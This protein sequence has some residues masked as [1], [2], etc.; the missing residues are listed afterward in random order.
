MTDVESYLTYKIGDV[1]HKYYLPI[2]VTIGLCGN[3]LSL[4]VLLQKKHRN[5][6]CYILMAALAVNDSIVLCVAG[7]DWTG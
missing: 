6:S 4:L 7:Y 1:I 3:I 5:N 2:I